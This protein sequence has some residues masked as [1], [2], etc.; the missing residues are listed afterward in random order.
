MQAIPLPGT[1]SHA[2]QP[3]ALSA[4]AGFL[5]M[6]LGLNPFVAALGAGF[7]SVALYRRRASGI[8]IRAGTGARLGAL[9]GLLFFAIAISVEA[10]AVAVL[11]QGAEV[12]NTMIE[13]VQQTATRYPGPEMQRLLD[14]VKTP[15]G[16][17]ALIV[18]SLICGFVAFLVLSSIGGALS[19]AFLGRN[20][21]R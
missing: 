9:S 4:L 13:K 19:A 12:R 20:D 1:W 14:L 2:A 6:V 3:C 11:H 18:A 5:L 8:A 15:D 21:R 17:T 10:L 7:L 16:L